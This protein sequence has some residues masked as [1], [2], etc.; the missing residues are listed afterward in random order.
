MTSGIGDFR[1]TEIMAD[2]EMDIQLHFTGIKKI[3]AFTLSQ[4]EWIV[5]W[6]HMEALLWWSYTPS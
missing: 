5:Y 3:S 4:G 1:K 6:S 2:A